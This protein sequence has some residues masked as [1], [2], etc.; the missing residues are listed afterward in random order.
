MTVCFSKLT[1]VY[2]KRVNFTLCKLFLKNL[3]EKN[4]KAHSCGLGSCCPFGASGTPSACCSW[5]S[6]ACSVRFPAPWFPDLSYWSSLTFPLPTS[7]KFTSP[8]RLPITCSF[9][10][11]YQGENFQP[12]LLKKNPPFSPC[13]RSF[14]IVASSILRELSGPFWRIHVQSKYQLWY[15]QKS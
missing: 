13:W 5:P 3:I 7:I 1:N 11:A 2:F 9:R 4:E 8:S 14:P 6:K 10:L 12:Y 15:W